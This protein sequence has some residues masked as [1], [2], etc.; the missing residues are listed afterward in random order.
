LSY[1]PFAHLSERV[2]MN[3]ILGEG[4][5]I[6]FFQGD[7]SRFFDDVARLKPTLFSSVSGV[8]S[9][10]Y[11]EVK[12]GSQESGLFAH[13]FFN[14][15]IKGK[16]KNLRQGK[17]DHFLYD[18]LAFKRVRLS[19]AEL[20][21]LWMVEFFFFFCHLDLTNSINTKK[22]NCSPGVFPPCPWL[23]D[24]RVIWPHRNHRICD[25]DDLGRL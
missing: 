10:V 5:E 7:F 22:I 8:L 17:L 25:P 13:A 12:A 1:L 11:E 16:K 2:L 20:P 23:R 6:G 9:S 3:H 14:M 19:Q 4:G 24:V 21:S 15:A 18:K